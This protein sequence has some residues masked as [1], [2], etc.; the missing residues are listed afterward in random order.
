MIIRALTPQGDWTFGAGKANYNIAQLAVMENI[1]TRLYCFLNNCFFDMM[2]GMNWFT[3]LSTP[4]TEQQI[5]LTAR[6]IILQ[7]YGVVNVSAMSV[8]FD[9]NKRSLILQF[10]INTVFTSNAMLTFS[11]NLQQFLGSGS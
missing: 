2:S 11:M 1:Q 8:A 3:L 10:K 9:E 6:A 7:S 5:I 4:G